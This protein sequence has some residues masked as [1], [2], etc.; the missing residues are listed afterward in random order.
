MGFIGQEIFIGIG[1]PPQLIKG[2]GLLDFGKN[3]WQ[4]KKWKR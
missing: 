3:T 2:I 4:T 1:S